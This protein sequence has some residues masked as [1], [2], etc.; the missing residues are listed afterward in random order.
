MPSNGYEIAFE[1]ATAERIEIRAQ[2][3]KLLARDEMIDKLLECLTRLLPERDAPEPLPATEAPVEEYAG[4]E[5]QH[6]H[7]Q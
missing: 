4:H 7:D 1:Q 6:Q 3:E 5:G 2:L